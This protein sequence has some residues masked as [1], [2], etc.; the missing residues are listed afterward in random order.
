MACVQRLA[1]LY[2]DCAALPFAHGV[3]FPRLKPGPTQSPLE[4]SMRACLFTLAAACVFLFLISSAH[5]QTSLD[6][7]P[8]HEQQVSKDKEP[9]AILEIG[10]SMSWT[11]TGGAATF[12][13]NLFR[14]PLSFSESRCETLL[15]RQ[16][17]RHPRRSLRVHKSTCYLD[18]P[19]SSIPGIFN[20]P[21][22]LNFRRPA[23]KNRY[24]FSLGSSATNTSVGESGS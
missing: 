6:R 10:T 11:V 14:A 23:L 8:G 4:T 17:K 3:S 24:C 15:E 12:A 22:S 9:T 16:S 18:T 13:P 20:L 19:T 5:G 2:S 21:S 7:S 1:S